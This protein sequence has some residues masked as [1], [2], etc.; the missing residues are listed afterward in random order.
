MAKD[1]GEVGGMKILAL[2]GSHRGEKGCT[3]WLLDKLAEGAR[4]A[5]AD[6]ETVALAQQNIKLCTG[7]E[8]CH[9]SGHCV[10]EQEDDVQAIFARM[11]AADILIYATPVYVFSM[12][13]LM[14]TFLDRL[15]S[16]VG[17]DGLCLTR[18]GLFFHRVDPSYVKPI[19]VLTCCGNVEQ[20]TV[21]NVVSYFKTFSRFLDAPL[22]GILTR[23]SIGMMQIGKTEGQ[24]SQNPA[25]AAVVQAY[26]QAG[27]ELA[28]QGR[29]TSGTQNAANRQIMGIPFFDLLMKF[30]LFKEIAL[31]KRS[32]KADGPDGD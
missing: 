19:V 5:G 4:L 8:G 26:I 3:Q 30:R 21:K 2:N 14:K 24:V 9:I 23:K 11:K 27:K 13:G 20:E 16:T 7:C 15:N 1:E 28:T 18:S 25:I 6:F 10:Y 32:K 17:S 29:I 22:V 31:R 12:S